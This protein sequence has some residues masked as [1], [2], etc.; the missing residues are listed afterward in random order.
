MLASSSERPL[1]HVRMPKKK[2]KKS[3][4]WVDYKASKISD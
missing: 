3:A 1:R 4:G 2:G